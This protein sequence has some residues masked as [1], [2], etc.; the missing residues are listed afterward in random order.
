MM[1]TSFVV[2]ISPALAA[3]LTEAASAAEL[4][5][6]KFLEQLVEATLAERRIER[7]EA[8]R[9]GSLKVHQPPALPVFHP[10]K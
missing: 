10:E 8:A 2:K 4:P 3:E 1:R 9:L 5:P 7:I 6:V